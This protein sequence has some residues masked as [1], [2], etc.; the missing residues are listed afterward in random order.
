MR[1]YKIRATSGSVIHSIKPSVWKALVLSICVFWSSPLWAA[2]DFNVA[3]AQGEA[4][5][6]NITLGAPASPQNDDIW[7]AVVTSIDA[8]GHTFTDWTQIYQNSFASN[9]NISVWY[10]R[11]AGATPNLIVTHTAGA[12]IVG[13]IAQLRGCDTVGSPVDTLGTATTATNSDTAT[14]ATITPATSNTLLLAVWGYNDNLLV[15]TGPSGFSLGFAA[16]NATS[17]DSASYL[18]YKSHVS[19]ATGGFTASMTAMGTNDE[20]HAMLIAIA[21]LVATGAKTGIS[22]L[23]VGK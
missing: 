19:G 23:G 1:K 9:H 15:G 17:T 8:V 12:G 18:Y 21:E 5:N 14:F 6:G 20:P 11:Y 10:F 16:R 13:A 7:I 22:L 3:G 2:C 4:A